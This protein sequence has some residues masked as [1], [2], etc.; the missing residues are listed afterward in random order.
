MP[1]SSFCYFII[2]F[3]TH[4]HHSLISNSNSLIQSLLFISRMSP[5]PLLSFFSPK[6]HIK[7]HEILWMT[8]L[9]VSHDCLLILTK[10]ISNQSYFLYLHL[11]LQF[12]LYLFY[13]FFLPST[14]VLIFRI[15]WLVIFLSFSD[16]NMLAES[17][18]T[19][20]LDFQE[21]SKGELQYFYNSNPNMQLPLLIFSPPPLLSL[22]IFRLS[23]FHL[24]FSLFSSSAM[25]YLWPI[26]CFCLHYTRNIKL[27]SKELPHCKDLI[28]NLKLYM[29]MISVALFP[30]NGKWLRS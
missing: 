4:N 25:H 16:L 18:G 8:Y 11:L 20:H 2:F 30:L 12:S 24:Q 10:F 21:H 22:T 17:E 9:K 19:D 3:L 7:F 1:Y 5:S 27:F 15:M 23:S 6:S 14:W 13:L 26:T 29:F 28:S